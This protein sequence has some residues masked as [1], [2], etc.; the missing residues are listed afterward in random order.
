MNFAP[1]RGLCGKLSRVCRSQER[2]SSLTA[3]K[4]LQ[5]QLDGADADL[6]TVC[7]LRRHLLLSTDSWSGA[8]EKVGEADETVL[9]SVCTVGYSR[10]L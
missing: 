9:R 3:A 4:Y 2:N 6:L 7:F 8:P 10:P 5:R 1:E